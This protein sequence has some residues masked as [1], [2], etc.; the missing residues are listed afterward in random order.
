MVSD[1]MGNKWKFG[2]YL[3]MGT[4]MME[5]V[6]PRT[7]MQ[8]EQ[9]QTE[10]GREDD[11]NTD[12]NPAPKVNGQPDDFSTLLVNTDVQLSDDMTIARAVTEALH[13]ENPDKETPQTIDCASC[14]AVSR[15]LTTAKQ[16]LNLDMSKYSGDAYAAPA[17]FNVQ[18]VDQVGQ[19]PFAQ[20]AF[21][22]FKNQ[23]AFSQR[24][25]NESAVIADTLSPK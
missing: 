2:A 22:Y 3:R 18:R 7:D 6:I 17:R 16:E 8:K 1:Q 21:G 19:N 14:H 11:R 4:T 23:T 25:I 10:N 13:I 24:T 9:T 12:F 5:D 20:R 15:A